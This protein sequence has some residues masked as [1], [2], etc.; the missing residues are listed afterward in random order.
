MLAFAPW[1]IAL[2]LRQS[3][4]HREQRDHLGGLVRGRVMTR[5]M[6]G[7]VRAHDHAHVEQT[8]R[9]PAL[10]DRVSKLKREAVQEWKR[11]LVRRPVYRA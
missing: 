5:R 10:D 3:R 4:H 8:T 2:W 11:D 1:I 7:H 9:N 6:T